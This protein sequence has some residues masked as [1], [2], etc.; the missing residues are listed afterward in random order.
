MYKSDEP[1]LTLEEREEIQHMEEELEADKKAHFALNEKKVIEQLA[2]IQQTCSIVPIGRD[3]MYRRYW[4]FSSVHGLYIE[5]DEIHVDTCQ[6]KPIC[7]NISTTTKPKDENGS[8]KENDSV[9]SPNKSLNNSVNGPKV[10]PNV[11][12]DKSNSDE[13]I[14]LDDES[15]IASTDGQNSVPALPENEATRQIV[16]RQKN[17]W[18]FIS[19]EEEFEHL[20]NSLNGRGYR[21]SALRAALV[22]QRC[23]V[24][25]SI[26][27]CP[28]DMI[29]KDT[30][31]TDFNSED[32]NDSSK[33]QKSVVKRTSKG[34]IKSDSAQEVLE[35]NLRELLLDLEER[36]YVGA[37]GS[38]KVK[39]PLYKHLF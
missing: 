2:K 31:D 11:S 34:L 38:L 29:F 12:N 13:V 24:V 37:L 36:I 28:V 6:L 1:E 17:L 39:S 21:E 25:E 19:T 26:D 14:C 9:N 30:D 5:D 3:R 16:S 33:K 15:R 8:D 7:A 32:S 10:A 4:I 35:I 23:R 27:K 18:G 22:E 20:L